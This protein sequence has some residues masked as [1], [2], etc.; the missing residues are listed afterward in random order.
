MKI[1]F[2]S[3]NNLPLDKILKL[4]DLTVVVRSRQQVFFRCL[5]EL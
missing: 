3:D 5:Y 2:S 4:H 1:K